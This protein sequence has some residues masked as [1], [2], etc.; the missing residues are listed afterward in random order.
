MLSWYEL[1]GFQEYCGD[2][3]S[4]L[5]S[6]ILL[7]LRM[8][9]MCVM[10][11]GCL[12]APTNGV[13]RCTRVEGL[14]RLPHSSLV[15]SCQLASNLGPCLEGLQFW[16]RPVTV[17][18]HC[19]PVHKRTTGPTGTVMVM[20]EDHIHKHAQARTVWRHA[21]PEKNLGP[22]RLLLR[23]CLSQNATKILILPCECSW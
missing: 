5:L 6:E 21:P 9:S 12:P 11:S 13:D 20:V 1:S 16:A 2:F 3:S 7:L 17:Y 10:W 22:L 19:Y 23:P 8:Q 4:Y 15:S 18:C 14:K